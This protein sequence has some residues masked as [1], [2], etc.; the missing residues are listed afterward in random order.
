MRSVGLAITLVAAIFGSTVAGAQ[1]SVPAAGADASAPKEP[2][3]S[4][5]NSHPSG[6]REAVIEAQ[7]RGA[8]SESQPAEEMGQ[9]PFP[10]ESTHPATGWAGI[11][12]QSGQPVRPLPDN[13]TARAGRSEPQ[14]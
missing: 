6:S 11:A 7:T 2:G 12:E 4:S 5:A 10:P 14:S 3:S 9:T 1:Q 8:A 13:P